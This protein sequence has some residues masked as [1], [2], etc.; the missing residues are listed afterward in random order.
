[1]PVRRSIAWG[2]VV[3]LPLALAA[4][5]DDNKK[6]A[7]ATTGAK[8]PVSVTMTEY[9][10]SVSGSLTAG[11]TIRLRN[12]GKQ[13]HMMGMGK[14]KPGKTLDDV[15]AALKQEPQGEDQDPTADIVDQVGMPAGLVTPGHTV[16]ITVPSLEAGDYALVCF[17]PTEGGGPF[18]AIQGMVSSLRV[19]AGSPSTPKA[20]AVYST[21]PGK[22]VTGPT[23][24]T[25]G[26]HVLRI[27]GIDAKGLEPGL[28]KLPPGKTI[29]QLSKEID[30]VF[31]AE[32]GPP[33]GAGLQ[34]AESFLF[35]LFDFQDAKTVYIGITLEPGTYALVTQDS[36]VQNKPDDPVEKI[37]IT[38]T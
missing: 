8:A 30:A 13:L 16:D 34:V 15:K 38:V 4:C 9:A 23:T 5:G 35:G 26:T 12:A 32:G 7:T 27:D 14:L 21:T 19:V 6:S 22:P 1:M 17:L 20:D 25:A 29:A 18:H 31:E 3:S 2:L 36:D 28:A 10:Y 11:N 33:K 24:L 37:L